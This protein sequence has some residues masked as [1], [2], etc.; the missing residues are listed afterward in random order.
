MTADGSGGEPSSCLGSVP[1]TPSALD[2]KPTSFSFLLLHFLFRLR[3]KE[4]VTTGVQRAT[5]L[6]SYCRVGKPTSGLWGPTHPAL[7]L[8]DSGLSS[9]EVVVV[10]QAGLGRWGWTQVLQSRR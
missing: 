6:L 5:R 8:L 1:D 2:N 10:V 9:P 7:S 3:I 4:V